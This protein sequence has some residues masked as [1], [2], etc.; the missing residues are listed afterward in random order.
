MKNMNI[1]D[2]AKKIASEIG[3]TGFVSLGLRIWTRSD[4]ARYKEPNKIQGYEIS[5]KF[6][7]LYKLYPNHKKLSVRDE[8]KSD[9]Y[10]EAII[11]DDVVYINRKEYI[12]FG[13][14]SILRNKSVWRIKD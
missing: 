4:G 3:A 13:S 7:K 12:Q 6:K 2:K 14:L 1:Y 11:I 8:F 10:H 5:T 9:P